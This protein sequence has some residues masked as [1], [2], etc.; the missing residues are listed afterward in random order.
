MTNYCWT[1]VQAEAQ[2]MFLASRLHET[3]TYGDQPYYNHLRDVVAVIDAFGGSNSDRV[4][5]WLHDSV[6]D[7]AMTIPVVEALF[8]ER[9]AKMVDACTGVGKNRKERNQSIYNKIAAYPNAAFIKVAD[10][11]ANLEAA[12]PKHKA[13]YRKEKDA[14]FENVAKYVGPEMQSRLEAAYN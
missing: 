1:G 11:I 3:Q 13:M 9:V 6:E 4:A 8:G 7:T 14:F 10:R 5:G 12:G 2:A